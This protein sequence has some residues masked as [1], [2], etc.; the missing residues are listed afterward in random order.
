MPAPG[1]SESGEAEMEMERDGKEAKTSS[2]VL[3]A[4]SIGFRISGV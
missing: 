1:L 3:L 4:L 2:W